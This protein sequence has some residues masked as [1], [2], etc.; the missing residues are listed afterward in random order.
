[1][2][3]EEIFSFDSSFS[4]QWN[5]LLGKTPLLKR[6]GGPSSRINATAGCTL[7][8]QT[9][10]M[11][12]EIGIAF[13]GVMPCRVV[14][15]MHTLLQQANLKKTT[16]RH[17]PE[18]RQLYNYRRDSLKS[19]EGSKLTVLW[20]T[21]IHSSVRLVTALRTG[22]SSNSGSKPDSG[23]T[24]I[25]SPKIPD[26]PEDHPAYLVIEVFSAGVKGP[27]REPGHSPLICSQI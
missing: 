25:P 15:K 1:M 7:Q 13:W 21:A 16:R 17:T 5:S 22:C 11:T 24:F 20:L 2:G 14:Q 23:Q 4:F 10:P 19:L 3:P 9:M 27:G 6:D 18:D 8:G 26:R 12:W